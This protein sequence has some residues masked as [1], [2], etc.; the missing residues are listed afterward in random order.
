MHILLGPQYLENCPKSQSASL[1]NAF[2]DLAHMK[3][4]DN[5]CH[6]P[7]LVIFGKFD[8]QVLTS[9]I[10]EYETSKGTPCQS[11][12]SFYRNQKLAMQVISQ[13][14]FLC[15]QSKNQQCKSCHS[16]TSFVLEFESSDA[17]HVIVRLPLYQNLKLAMQVMSQSQDHNTVGSN[18]VEAQ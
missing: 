12:T 18:D 3:P 5:S 4:K 7:N 6:R 15:T 2:N 13:S 11:P 17:N 8:Q 16:P 9:F 10:P 1:T 14:D